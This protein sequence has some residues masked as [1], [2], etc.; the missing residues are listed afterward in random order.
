V[1]LIGF[2]VGHVKVEAYY[3]KPNLWSRATQILHEAILLGPHPVVD[4]ELAAQ[5]FNRHLS[6]ATLN[7]SSVC[8][9]AA[10]AFVQSSTTRHDR[11][12]E[13]STGRRAHAP[14]EAIAAFD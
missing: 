1:G 12:D 7:P 13:A 9:A 2:L 10:C 6:D 14:A 5:R 3:G 11:A 8:A 4:A